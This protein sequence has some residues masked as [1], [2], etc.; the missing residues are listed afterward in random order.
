MTKKIVAFILAFVFCF[1]CAAI[2]G[3]FGEGQMHIH[4][5]D[6]D[7]GEEETPTVID[8]P[9]VIIRYADGVS[10][11]IFD[12]EN[13]TVTLKVLIKDGDR[14][15]CRKGSLTVKYDGTFFDF[16]S[17]SGSFMN[18]NAGKTDVVTVNNSS[19]LLT[20]SVK[21]DTTE[22]YSVASEIDLTFSFARI[23]V[24]TLQER[25]KTFD[26]ELTF[27]G[28]S[29]RQSENKKAR[30]FTIT[31]CPHHEADVVVKNFPATCERYAH[32]DTIC[33][34]C[35][36]ILNSVNTGNIYALHV[37]DYENIVR[38][39]YASEYTTCDPSRSN[40]IVAEVECQVCHKLQWVSD[41]EY[42][43]GLDTSVKRYDS[44]TKQ[45]YYTCSNGHRI[46]AKIQSAGTSTQTGTH[47]HTYVLSNTINPTCTEVGYYVYKCSVCN[48]E[49]R[50][51][52]PAKG[53]VYGDPV[54]TKQPTCTEAGE[55][56]LTCTVCGKGQEIEP[57]AALGHDFEHG[58]VT[59][60][61]AATCTSAGSATHTCARCGVSETYTLP[62]DPAA[63]QYGE[64]TVS[65]PGTCQNKEVKKHVCALC[66]HE[67]SQEFDYGPHDYETEV[68]IAPTCYEDGLMT[69]T[70]KHGDDTYTEVIKCAGH[71]FGV[72]TSNGKG[73]TTKT[74]IDCG[75]TVTTTV[76]SKKTTKSVSHGPF[77]LTINN[78]ELAQKDIQLR[79]TEIDRASDEYSSHSIYLNALNAGLGKNYSIQNA[80]HVKLYI[81]GEEAEMTSDM[82]LQLAI[83]QALSSSKTAIIYYA[84][85]GSSTMITNMSDASRRKLTVT[86]PGKALA[87]AA[88][89]TIILA[90]EGKSV[91]PSSSESTTPVNPPSPPSSDNNVILPIVIIAVAVIAA[92]IVA[93][94]VIK[95]G[96]KSGFDF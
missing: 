52:I 40:Y 66:G 93:V 42:H 14:A 60:I 21:N 33:N 48:E 71:N 27:Y 57:I 61:Q 26:L 28:S 64:W 41:M 88:N 74:C 16:S 84:E 47:E 10:G 8:Q 78:T 6:D 75:L 79:V 62:I 24:E 37:Y 94:V 44:S 35:G 53:H 2:F 55:Q 5:E 70:C 95:N 86:M 90:V 51:E 15:S 54:V 76:T 30:S 22:P 38:Y 12:F 31:V 77:T 68:T 82:T 96:K 20:I 23:D 18:V 49:K 73:T 83:D 43:I 63:H 7:S 32:A 65:V 36:S 17:I 50:D 92:G 91:T 72:E 19:G 29:Y 11:P 89:D 25:S 9:T 45:Y 56:T 58:E 59:V 87:T 3:M 34:M 46:L 13:K 80:Y 67:E 1:G 69:Y 85:S 4:A 39:I 81:D